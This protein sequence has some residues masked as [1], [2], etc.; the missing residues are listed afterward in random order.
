MRRGRV[1]WGRVGVGRGNRTTRRRQYP[2]RQGRPRP[3][4][5]AQSHR[6]PAYLGW[7]GCQPSPSQL[8]RR[9]IRSRAGTRGATRGIA[10]LGGTT[11]IRRA[12][13]R[14]AASA[15]PAAT[16]RRGIATSRAA[17]TAH[18][19]A[20]LRATSGAE[21][22]RGVATARP[23]RSA[24]AIPR[25]ARAMRLPR[26]G[27]PRRLSRPVSR[28]CPRSRHSRPASPACPSGSKLVCLLR[29]R[30]CIVYHMSCVVLCLRSMLGVLVT[31]VR[32]TGFRRYS[33][34]GS[35][36]RRG[37]AGCSRHARCSRCSRRPSL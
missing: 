35:Q 11:G 32:W 31:W 37:G 8:C 29:L 7:R 15:R 22:S 3:A 30:V 19:A 34:V 16:I 2:P 18:H 36:E 26:T 25:P 23:A 10:R 4:P 12:V 14:P 17:V 6:G 28:V 20:T 13:S 21:T 24:A 9:S 33:W 1:R 5:R 27:R